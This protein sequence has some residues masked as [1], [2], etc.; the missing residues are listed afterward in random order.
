MMII[1]NYT[2]TITEVANGVSE[3]MRMLVML[4]VMNDVEFIVR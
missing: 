1:V 3:H 4:Y 2:R